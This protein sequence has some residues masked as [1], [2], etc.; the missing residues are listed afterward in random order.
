M[1]R[2][3]PLM[4]IRARLAVA[5]LGLLL[6]L[7]SLAAA[8]GCE[9]PSPLRFSVIPQR[10][11]N[12]QFANLA[13][14]FTHL[15]Q[16][17]GRKIQIVTPVSY[18][19][20]VEGL[21]DGSIDFAE[22]GAASFALAKR[23]APDTR[24]IATLAR[25]TSRFNRDGFSYR[26]L[27]IT[28]RQHQGAT[29]IEDLQGRSL[30]LTDPAST[31]GALV[32]RRMFPAQIGG[33]SLERY[34]RRINYSGSHDRSIE[35]LIKGEVDAT[36]VASRH[37]EAQL[38]GLHRLPE[39]FNILWQSPPIPDD[40]FVVR[41]ALC[42]ALVRQIV[43]ALLDPSPDMAAFLRN[44]RTERFVPVKDDNYRTILDLVATPP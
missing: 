30:A 3:P 37:F 24:A 28:S 41:G 20:V 23:L 34:F 29:R 43:A 25:P 16:R 17:L 31:S 10:N 39:D 21:A 38:A 15:E 13:P 35:L 2:F 27:L 32:P 5:A 8:A 19:A 18:G 40:P 9:S 22:L 12:E 7:T 4:P 42:P 6:G 1:R 11:L 33:Q 14:L 26:S 36:F 44:S